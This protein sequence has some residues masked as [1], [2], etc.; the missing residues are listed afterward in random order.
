MFACE[1][2][3]AEEFEIFLRELGEKL[4]PKQKEH[5]KK[6]GLVKADSKGEMQSTL[7]RCLRKN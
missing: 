1:Q 4:T 5:L 6:M 7:K 2:T 3:V